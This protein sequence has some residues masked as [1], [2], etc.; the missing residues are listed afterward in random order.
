MLKKHLP[1]LLL[2]LG[3]V[4]LAGMLGEISLRTINAFPPD[5]HAHDPNT[6]LIYFA[7]NSSVA[8]QSACAT[9]TVESNAVGFHAFPFSP[10]KTEHEFRIAIV[11]DSFTEALQVS[12]KENVAHLLEEKLNALP[13]AHPTYTV[14]PFGV[15]GNGTYLNALYADTYVMDFAP[16]LIID[17]F[18]L[19][20]DVDN[21][22]R[23]TVYVPHFN[24]EGEL[25]VAP[26]GEFGVTWKTKV[27]AII[28]HS[29]LVRGSYYAY[30]SM[31]Q[32]YADDAP[33]TSTIPTLSG[34]RQIYLV[35]DVPFW[36]DAW[37]LEARL[38]KGFNKLSR[39]HKAKFMVLSISDPISIH[40]ELTKDAFP[41]LT[42][43]NLVKPEKKLEQITAELGIPTLSLGPIFRSNAS[44]T[45]EM[46]A[47][48]CDGHWN[49]T[50]HQWASDALFDYFIKNRPLIGIE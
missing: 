3:S 26:Q 30:L 27:K 10:T 16:D 43:I 1:S 17:A 34:A 50:G 23:G 14:R 33:T 38:L 35:E 5:I 31:K 4:M 2:I 42:E 7:P 11:G 49:Q 20:N 47:W 32:R 13:R 46:S 8:W 21:D 18:F 28:K 6:G 9:N 40:P 37:K 45:G 25:L 36:E 39:D 19:G 41:Q 15:S 12:R 29:A 22:A 24:N 44:S 48:P